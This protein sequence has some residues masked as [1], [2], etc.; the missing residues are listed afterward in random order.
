[1]TQ[2]NA[3][4]CIISQRKTDW[5][6][7][8]VHSVIVFFV[9]IAVLGFVCDYLREL[10]IYLYTDSAESG[11]EKDSNEKVISFCTVV[12]RNTTVFTV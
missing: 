2:T 10:S 5:I 7:G 4:S 6:G 3:A 12:G 8:E 1:M 11:K 9:V